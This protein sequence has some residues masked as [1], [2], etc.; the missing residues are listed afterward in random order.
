METINIVACDIVSKSNL[1]QYV[2]I[3]LGCVAVGAIVDLFLAEDEIGKIHAKFRRWAERL[4]ETPLREWQVRIGL[5]RDLLY[6]FA[7]P[8]LRKSLDEIFHQELH[9]IS[10]RMLLIRR[11]TTHIA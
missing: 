7:Y 1:L 8:D 5:F 9:G 11:T 6:R 4:R 3:G 2:I 10:L